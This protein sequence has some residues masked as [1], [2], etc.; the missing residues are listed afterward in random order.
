MI[1]PPRHMAH[2]AFKLLGN[3]GVIA[4]RVPEW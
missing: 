3:G 2:A 4:L 1:D